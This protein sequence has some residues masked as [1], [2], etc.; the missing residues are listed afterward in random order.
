M[1]YLIFFSITLILSV[2][3]FGKSEYL[4]TK[5]FITQ[6]NNT[7]DSLILK[8]HIDIP[9]NVFPQ[10]MI[11][12]ITPIVGQQKFQTFGIGGEKAIGNAQT[13]AKSGGK[14]NYFSAVQYTGGWSLDAAK[15]MFEIVIYKGAKELERKTI[16][17]GSGGPPVGYYYD[18]SDQPIF[19]ISVLGLVIS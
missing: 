5:N 14:L 7:L 1:K 8:L 6:Q 17:V 4:S 15:I 19:S 3:L 10:K 18:D 2:P 13:I 11:A 16:E 9:P 12:Q